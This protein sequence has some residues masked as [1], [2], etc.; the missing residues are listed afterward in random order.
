[1]EESEVIDSGEQEEEGKHRMRSLKRAYK[2]CEERMRRK[3]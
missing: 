1:V 2:E 3:D